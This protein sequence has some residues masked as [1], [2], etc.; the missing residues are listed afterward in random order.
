V[1]WRD[2]LACLIVLVV[3]NLGIARTPVFRWIS[4][5]LVVVTNLREMGTPEDI[6]VVEPASGEYPTLVST[7]SG[8]LCDRNLRS[9][10]F[11]ILVTHPRE[12]CGSRD[13]ASWN[14]APFAGRR[15]YS[16]LEWKEETSTTFETNIQ[17]WCPADIL[18]SDSKSKWLP[19]LGLSGQYWRCYA[20]PSALIGSGGV[21][22]CVQRGLTLLPRQFVINSVLFSSLPRLDVGVF[23]TL[24][25]KNV[26]A[27][28][29]RSLALGDVYGLPSQIPL[30]GT[31]Q[32]GHSC[33]NYK[34]QIKFSL[35]IPM[36]A[37][38]FI[39]SCLRF[40][41]GV[42]RAFED[43]GRSFVLRLIVL[44]IEFLICQVLLGIA[45][46]AL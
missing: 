12:F 46:V 39:F 43:R 17:R 30:G 8:S 42:D 11:Q 37:I 6:F 27:F 15:I 13:F 33:E 41:K 26:G 21:D 38:L 36:L 28:S 4:S 31:N 1:R 25:S 2:R 20:E 24:A 34:Q 18:D 7:I 29:R 19:G 14:L 9:R 5:K 10:H 45:L 23:H 35:K 32:C 40:L 44:P 16:R 3:L 22:A